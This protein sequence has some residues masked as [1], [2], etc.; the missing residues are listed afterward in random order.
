[1][2]PAS[3]R[4]LQGGGLLTLSRKRVPQS[5]FRR[6]A[7]TSTRD[8]CATRERDSFASP[9]TLLETGPRKS[10]WAP[11]YSS[12]CFGKRESILQPLLVTTTTSSMRTPPRPG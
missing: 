6:D 10:W 7:E 1:M 11:S 9:P 12:S 3:R 5:S 8:E 4:Q 2:L